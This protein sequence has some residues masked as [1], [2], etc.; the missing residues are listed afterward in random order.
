LEKEKADTTL[1]E[2]ITIEIFG[3]PFTFTSDADAS[4]AKEVADFL[5][6][7]VA[8][9]E[10]ELVR[11]TPHITRQAILVMTALNIASENFELR[12]NQ[13]YM[14]KTIFERTQRLIHELDNAAAK[15]SLR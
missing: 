4:T 9:M 15:M 8:R 3:K 1:E 6:R 10:S 5:V 7:E 14:K 13:A 2:L 11:K 12:K